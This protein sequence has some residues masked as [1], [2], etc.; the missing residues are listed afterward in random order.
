MILCR[1]HGIGAFALSWCK[2]TSDTERVVAEWW[3]SRTRAPM[4]TGLNLEE[5]SNVS[6][7]PSG[8]VCYRLAHV[9]A[10][11][12]AK[13]RSGKIILWILHKCQEPIRLS[14][15]ALLPLAFP[16]KKKPEF[17][18]GTFPLGTRKRPA[19][20][21]TTKNQNGN[22]DGKGRNTEVQLFSAQIMPIKTSAAQA[23]A[24]SRVA[25]IG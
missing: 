10:L 21:R 19:N 24:S 6:P 20:K 23:S 18:T 1:F 4:T 11:M 2:R 16:G 14:S 8:S 25:F 3:R 5:G 7:L 22:L 12:A 9:E 17:P 15:D 13:N